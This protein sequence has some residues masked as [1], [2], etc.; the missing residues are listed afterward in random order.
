MP[1]HQMHAHQK[2][3][4]RPTTV[5][6]DWNGTLLDDRQIC[7]RGINRLL[8]RRKLARLDMERYR[9]IFTFPVRKYYEAAGFD[10]SREAF[11][12]PAEEFILEYRLLLPE[13][14]LFPDVVQVLEFFRLSGIRQYVLSAMEQD[15]LVSSIEARGILPFFHR[16]YGIGD[17]LAFSK[18][19]RGKELL[20][21]NGIDPG[22]VL[23]V[24]DTL[25]D[26]EVAGELGLDIV[27]VGRGHQHPDRLGG[28]GRTVID[29]L[30]QLKGWFNG[31]S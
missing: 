5:I 22:R 29:N 7:L 9:E 28:E 30:E 3:L 24:G 11:E 21:D 15:A 14:E 6:W 27:L 25:H 1:D 20:K 26:L 4:N 13:A 16:I 18:L 31:T 19:L 8:E 12:G 17:N 10:F 23:M 2:P